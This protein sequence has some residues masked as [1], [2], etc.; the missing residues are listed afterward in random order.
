MLQMKSWPLLNTALVGVVF[1][2]SVRAG[3]T[4]SP[5][6]ANPPPNLSAA[7]LAWIDLGAA[8]AAVS[9]RQA[10]PVQPAVRSIALLR[11][12]ER[13]VAIADRAKAF[14]RDHPGHARSPEARVLEVSLMIGA[15]RNGDATVEGRLADTVAGLRTNRA[16]PARHRAAAAGAYDFHVQVRRARS[17]EERLA[18]VEKVAR[19]LMDEF[20][21]EPQG[22]QS[23]LTLA[24]IS[25]DGKAEA[26]VSELARVPQHEETRREA[27]LFA[28]K[29]ALSGQ[30]LAAELA[31]ANHR[32]E[33][34][35][36]RP[37]LVYAWASWSPG[38]LKFAA[39]LK[40]RAP[41]AHLI[42]VC[43]DT[44]VDAATQLA[45]AQGLPGELIYDPRGREGALAQR[46]GLRSAP[47]LLIC[48]A[49]GV[50]REVRGT[51]DLDRK[52]KRFG[53]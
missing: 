51:A 17:Q 47:E 46:L 49:Q 5:P 53:L 29:L 15:A 7:E 37:T 4:S 45:A 20:P 1:L 52:L 8:A 41:A 14:Y 18:A 3:D 39:E 28:R 44:D 25:P 40:R 38:S 13:M 42:G 31:G 27:E 34:G 9:S 2:V 19:G 22:F 33:V 35:T 43:L 26:I 16:V 24:Q 21:T 48:D 12:A 36:G 30:P 6:T 10:L 23:L 11:E 32:R 50:I